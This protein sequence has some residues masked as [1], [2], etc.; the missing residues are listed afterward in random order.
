MTGPR[1]KQ[2]NTEPKSSVFLSLADSYLEVND[3]Q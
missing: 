3:C 1:I 2:K